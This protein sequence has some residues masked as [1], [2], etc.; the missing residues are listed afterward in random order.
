MRN[1]A[2]ITLTAVIVMTTAVSIPACSRGGGAAT[3]AGG[4][5]GGGAGGSK[6][7]RSP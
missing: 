2:G 3:G 1:F 6:R 5:G 7:V 4:A